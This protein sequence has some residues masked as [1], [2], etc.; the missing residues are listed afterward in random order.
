VGLYIG[1]PYTVATGDFNGD[2]CADIAVGAYEDDTANINDAGSVEVFYGSPTGVQTTGTVLTAASVSGQQPRLNEEFGYSLAVGDFNHDGYA[3]LVVGAPSWGG[4]TPGRIF[5]FPGSRLFIPGGFGTG[6]VFAEG[7]GTVPGV[8]EGGDAF[9][10]ALSAGD[11]N[12]DN[13][14]DLAV[15]VPGENGSGCVIVLR[16]SAASTL[17][18]A[19][20]AKIWSQDTAGVLGTA[21]AGDEFGAALASGDFLGNHRTDLAIGVPGET[22]DGIV[23]EG[24]VNVLLSS[25]S[26]GLSATGNELWEESSTGPANYDAAFGSALATGDF[27]GDGADDLAVGAPK[28]ESDN[29]TTS[30][31]VQILS[32]SASGLSG[33]INT[34][35]SGDSPRILGTPSDYDRYGAGLATLHITSGT[36]SDLIIGAPGVYTGPDNDEEYNGMVEVLPSSPSGLTGTGAQAF[37]CETPGLNGGC[38][39]GDL[40]D[41]IA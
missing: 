38:D 2:G 18:T 33:S 19:T 31:M 11:F 36:R 4:W 12:G 17:L 8:A 30:G 35:W 10:Y 13:T 41:S 32:G 7:D 24:S 14:T 20:G 39:L 6:R 40:G 26:S 5:I 21:E 28:T 22:A 3:D 16:G 9:G 1:Q 29:D 37:K 23:G 25:G 15:G 34:R 27:N